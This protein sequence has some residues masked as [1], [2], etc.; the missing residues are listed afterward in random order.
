MENFNIELI[1]YIL[2]GLA[3]IGLIIAYIPQT[4]ELIKVKNADGISHFFWVF[5]SLSTSYS[6]FNLYVTFAHGF[7]L[8]AQTINAVAAFLIL[9]RVASLKY[10]NLKSILFISIYTTLNFIFY[11]LGT[12]ELA[13]TIASI[14]IVL[15]Y[16]DQIIYFI[17]N[18]KSTGTNPLMYLIFSLSI[19][20]LAVSMI[21]SET[22]L[23]ITTT[24]LI[25]AVLLSVC[26]LLSIKYKNKSVET[27]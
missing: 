18:K 14:A 22:H 1:I 20:M 17:K 3:S 7:I 15:A 27:N 8:F 24:E 6:M 26:L 16:I 25:N 2:T 21:L 23:Y 11:I 9:I 19:L 5:I 12:V 4:T 10:N 13:Q